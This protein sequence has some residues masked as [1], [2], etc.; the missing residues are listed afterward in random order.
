MA[1]MYSSKRRKVADILLDVLADEGVSHVFGNPGSTEMPLMDALVDRPDFTYVLGLQEAS[2]VGM[3]DGYALQSGKPAFVNLHT[4]GGLGNAM[5]I[6][7]AAQ[8][9]QTPMVV[10]AG[11]QDT[12]HLFS[13]PWLSGDLQKLA[14]PVCKW[15]VEIRRGEDV[16]P[17][18]RRAFSIARQPPMGPVFLSFPMDVLEQRVKPSSPARIHEA[19]PEGF[20]NV[21]PAMMKMLAARRV[22]IVIGDNVRE[23]VAEC[24]VAAAHAGGYPVFGTQLASAAAYPT[25]DICWAGFL[26][27]DMA[28]IRD[29]LQA[30][31]CIVLIGSR[32]FIAYP[33]R[34]AEPLARETTLIQF[35]DHR[36]AV[37]IDLPVDMSVVGDL[38][39]SVF[40]LAQALGA[41]VGP[42]EARKRL[43]SLK[44][45]S[46]DRVA[47][48]RASILQD[49][50]SPMS[51]DVAVLSVMDSLLPSTIIVNEA[52]AT[53]G[54]VQKAMAI[55]PGQYFFARGGVLG[56]AMPAAVGMAF[57][58]D[59]PVACFTG[60][61]GA[62]YSP[63]ALW[64]AARHDHRVVFVVFNNARYN[65]LMKAARDL[66]YKNAVDGKF[67]G[68]DVSQPAIDY[69][70]LAASFGIPAFRIDD[71]ASIGSVVREAQEL[72]GPSLVEILIR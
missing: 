16:E 46:S 59:R 61:G 55:S 9:S 34:D 31:D 48:T 23:D 21:T 72:Q 63:Q 69:Q 17:A 62:L 66:G 11:Q 65:V 64:S 29:Q 1:D 56:W 3:A 15:S 7:V 52:A 36:C 53:F 37:G 28:E 71:R 5:G 35:A 68:M 18:L 41:H 51:Q 6:L 54:P 26:R 25:R 50:A 40:A 12:R 20:P 45:S 10:T 43:D 67:V 38:R 60:D 30:Y 57:A 58:S 19:A 2:A 44:K 4:A 8:T 27:P 39:M 42:D 13:D 70:K 24:I 49:T 22:G 47:Q 14:Q 32:A 33:Y